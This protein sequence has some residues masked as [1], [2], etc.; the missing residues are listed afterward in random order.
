MQACP[1]IISASRAQLIREFYVIYIMTNF[2]RPCL[3]IALLLL[4]TPFFAIADDAT[5]SASTSTTSAA[6]APSVTQASIITPPAGG[7]PL[8]EG[9]VESQFKL[10]GGPDIA[11]S[12]MVP[13]T[14]VPFAQA[15]E[16]QSIKQPAKVWD[17]QLGYTVPGGIKKGDAL[18]VSIWARSTQTSNEIHE[19]LSQFCLDAHSGNR[20]AA[21]NFSGNSQWQ[22]YAWAFT[23]L[24]DCAPNSAGV[25]LRGG[26]RPQT[27]QLGG[28]QMI[29]YGTTVAAA[30]LPHSTI[31]Y[32]GMEADAP[33]RKAAADRIEK[34]RKADVKVE[35]KDASGQPVTGATVR[36]QQTKQEFGFGSCVTPE[37]IMGTGPD[38]DHYRQIIKDDFSKVVFENSLKWGSWEKGAKAGHKQTLDAMHWLLDNGV[39]IRGHNL[40]WPGW[41]KMPDDMKPYK[42]DK[43]AL[44][45]HIEDH[46]KDEVGGVKGMVTDWD[47]VNEPYG[48]HEVLDFLGQ[49]VMANWFKI[50]NSVDPKPILLV[51]DFAGFLNL[52]Q[53]T[54]Q[55]DYFEKTLQ[56][57]KDQGAPI[58]GLGI[59]SHF[60]SQLTAPEELLKELDRWAALGLDIEITEFDID[61][62]DDQVQAQYTRDFMT[63]C[64]SNPSVTT[65]LIWGFWQSADWI[66]NGALY[67]KDWS[68][69]P[70]GQAWNDLVL[71]EWH[72]DVT[73]DTDAVGL[74]STRGFMGQYQVTVT[75]HGA[76]KT[77]SLTL[78]KAGATLSAV[79]P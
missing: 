43:V 7:T 34:Y 19:A 46:I 27:I 28:F 67:R 77:F 1:A 23:A 65:I 38:N 10:R 30:D 21:M 52:G 74:V 45:Q 69:K 12:K 5:N 15:I 60:G 3:S 40:V 72:T 79:M 36:L 35:V 55:K 41:V 6:S 54:S 14:G 64:F 63:A 8:F 51:N 32:P 22:Q 62:P 57:L 76:T 66:P 70:N 58:G 47:V 20:L 49:D 4:Y 29:N 33:W 17:L 37:L 11:A 68:I 44:E 53:D 73:A 78:P 56:H 39:E 16:M 50:A 31:T 24:C 59:E 48:E 2:F 61:V 26:Y 13:A 75:Y 42:G 18:W 25:T 71:K 9:G